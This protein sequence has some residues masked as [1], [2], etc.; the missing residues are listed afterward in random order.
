[1]LPGRGGKSYDGGC[2]CQHLQ[3]EIK[4]NERGQK[5]AGQNQT[6]MSNQWG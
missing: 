2:K 6:A 1:M 3:S 4:W 5:E